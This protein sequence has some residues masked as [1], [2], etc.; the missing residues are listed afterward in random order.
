VPLLL[1]YPTTRGGSDVEEIEGQADV[2]RVRGRGQHDAT[3]DESGCGEAASYAAVHLWLS[4]WHALAEVGNLG[5]EPWLVSRG[6]DHE[7]LATP[8]H[9]GAE[10]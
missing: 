9:L 10:P 6:G 1:C 4:S 8:C 7:P 5:A 3:W 2:E